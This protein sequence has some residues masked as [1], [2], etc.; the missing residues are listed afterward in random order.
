MCGALLLYVSLL[1]HVR[2][3]TFVHVIDYDQANFIL[4]G[5]E[6]KVETMRR[7]NQAVPRTGKKLL[8]SNK[9]VD[10]EAICRK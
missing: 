5:Y 8:F 10:V 1:S 2:V 9:K 4:M 6:S 7:L 3:F